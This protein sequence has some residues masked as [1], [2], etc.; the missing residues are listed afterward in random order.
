[1]EGEKGR[2]LLE[3]QSKFKGDERFKLGEEFKEDDDDEKDTQ[4]KKA[5]K[6]PL[7]DEPE[8]DISKSIA[9]EKNQSMDLL[10]AMFGEEKVEK[11]YVILNF[12][13]LEKHRN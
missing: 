10:R 5:R 2:E 3:L 4:M 11:T 9:E 13:L 1:M 8:D 7:D 12:L 6:E